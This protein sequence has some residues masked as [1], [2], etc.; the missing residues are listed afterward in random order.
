MVE[1]LR[2]AWPFLGLRSDPALI[3]IFVKLP[4]PVW[5]V[6]FAPDVSLIY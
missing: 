1:Q 4:V 3:M 6:T 5:G 2:A